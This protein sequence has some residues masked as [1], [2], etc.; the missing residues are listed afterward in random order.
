MTSL[1]RDLRYGVRMLAKSP[2]FTAVAVVTLALGIGANTAIFTVA[3]A[4]LLRPL[5]F[6][7]PDQIVAIREEVPDFERFIGGRFPPGVN[8]LFERENLTSFERLSSLQLASQH[9][10]G[11]EDPERLMS[12]WTTEDFLSIL[13]ARPLHGRLLQEQ[14]LLDEARVVVISHSLWMRQFAGDPAIVGTSVRL[15]GDSFTVV[16]ILPADFSFPWRGIRFDSWSPISLSRNYKERD[17][18]WTPSYTIARLKAGV[19][20]E[21]ARAELEVARR[22]VHPEN[23]SGDGRILVFRT[24]HEDLVDHVRQGIVLLVAA[25]GCVLLIACVNLANLLLGRGLG[26]QTEMAVRNA[27]GAGRRRI[28]QQVFTESLL[29]AL[30]GGALGVLVAYW[31]VQGLVAVSFARIPRASDIA[32]D[33]DVAVYAFGLSLVTGLIFGVLPALRLSRFRVSES[34]KQAGQRGTASRGFKRMQGA[35]VVAEIALSVVLVVGAGLMVNTFVRLNQIELGFDRENVL[36]VTVDPH[37]SILRDRD[38]R[39][40]FHDEVTSRVRALPGVESAAWTSYLPPSRVYVTQKFRL[41][42]EQY[43]SRDKMP[44]ANSRF[45]TPG[46]FAV[47]RI[48]LLEGRVFEDQDRLRSARLLVISETMARKYWPQKSAVGRQI[49]L[50]ER[51]EEVPAEVIGVVADVKTHGLTEQA[52][53]VVYMNPEQI[54]RFP[55]SRIVLRTSVEPLSLVPALKSAIR[56]IDPDQAFREVTTLEQHF[57]ANTEYAEP[58]FYTALLGAFGVLALLLASVGL[59]GVLSFMVSRR[60][61]E[62]GLRMALGAQRSN[63]LRQVM[64]D[65]LKLTSLGLGIGVFAAVYAAEVLSDLLYGI[66]PTDTLTYVCVAGVLTL[67]SLV[68]CY[69]PARRATHVDP[70]TALRYE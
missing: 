50:P 36:A 57:A 44:F 63:V 28:A 48:G 41:P 24:L 12:A 55:S 47:L 37:R 22:R 58:R 46:F 40:A 25:V 5:P 65:G 1:W 43:A 4:V 15:N 62:I 10:T 11:V 13:G 52:R 14:D 45:A 30:L 17:H 34:L 16:G 19:T 21:E 2:G 18:R 27:L 60:S 33:T 9:L 26:R 39:L 42:G 23:E 49:I 51:R 32:I 6:P 35:L 29:V 3:N 56:E 64:G 7:E 8:F 61:R 69:L 59:Y 53:D 38:R 20:M 70:M 67:V 68:A 31:G 66:S 54:G